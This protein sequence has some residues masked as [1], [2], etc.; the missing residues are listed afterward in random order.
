ML[1]LSYGIEG[2]LIACREDEI[3]V[4][5]DRDELR[6]HSWVVRVRDEL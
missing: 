4:L 5:K 6:G 1:L 2:G 3:R